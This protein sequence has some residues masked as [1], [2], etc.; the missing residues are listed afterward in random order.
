MSKKISRILGKS[1][2]AILNYNLIQSVGLN[3]ACLFGVLAYKCPEKKDEFELEV[4]KIERM[5]G[6]STFL[7]LKA[8]EK[9]ISHGLIVKETKGMPPVNWYKLDSQKADDL[10]DGMVGRLDKVHR[11]AQRSSSTGS[12]KGNAGSDDSQTTSEETP[13]VNNKSNNTRKNTASPE[14]GNGTGEIKDSAGTSVLGITGEPAIVG[15]VGNAGP[16][17]TAGPLGETGAAS[18]IDSL[19]SQPSLASVSQGGPPDSTLKKDGTPR[20]DAR[21]RAFLAYFIA[22]YR[23]AHGQDPVLDPKGGKNTV[24]ARTILKKMEGRSTELARIV[25]RY[26]ANT[27]PFYAEKGWPL[28]VLAADTVLQQHSDVAWQARQKKPIGTASTPI[29][30]RLD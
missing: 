23:K 9:L 1:R 6:L 2:F 30:R 26:V 10:L 12:T 29:G 14:A 4:S 28:S 17:A 21:E 25:T 3:A 24:L 20:K 15:P 5:L 11:L 18:K 16:A 8:E 22:E 19:P 13:A 27:E 7:R